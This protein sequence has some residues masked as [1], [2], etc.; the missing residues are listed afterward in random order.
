MSLRKLY[1][2][3]LA[4]TVAGL[5]VAGTLSV[6]IKEYEVPTPRSRPHDP[7]LA[8]DGSLWYTGQAANKLG[9]LD[10]KT[11]EFKEFPLKTPNSGPHGL[12]ADKEGNI[13]FTAISGGYIGKL[14]PKTGA[15]AEYHAPK[16]AEIDPHTPVFDHNGILWFTNEETNYIGRL[17]PSNGKMTLAKSPTPHAVPHGIVVSLSHSRRTLGS[18]WKK[19]VPVSRN[20]SAF[21]SETAVSRISHPDQCVNAVPRRILSA[22]ASSE[23]RSNDFGSPT[24]MPRLSGKRLMLALPTTVLSG[25]LDL[26]HAAELHSNGLSEERRYPLRTA[27][28]ASSKDSFLKKRTFFPVRQRHFKHV[29]CSYRMRVPQFEIRRPPST[30]QWTLSYGSI[31]G[32]TPRNPLQKSAEPTIQCPTNHGLPKL[33]DSSVTI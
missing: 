3:I 20:I 11:G 24:T 12:V 21:E 28:K 33:S 5:A 32:R 8:P 6:Q 16:G 27:R 25:R 17:D 15:I 10:P 4:T 19:L 29:V 9:R 13:W 18:V 2:F 1:P 7:A 30:R 31:L 14:D 23:R 26:T 22:E